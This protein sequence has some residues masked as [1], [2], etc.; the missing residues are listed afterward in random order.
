M[1][2]Y[3][4]GVLINQLSDSFEWRV[5]FLDGSVSDH[6]C[7]TVPS[8]KFNFPPTPGATVKAKFEHANSFLPSL[9]AQCGSFEWFRDVTVVNS[10]VVIFA[11]VHF[12]NECLERDPF[13][14]N[15]MDYSIIENENTDF[16]K[17]VL[18]TRVLQ[19]SITS[20][21][22]LQNTDTPFIYRIGVCWEPISF[23]NGVTVNWRY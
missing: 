8:E 14:I 7:I 15:G 13:K 1:H 21:S 19:T 2:F 16:Q 22:N 4:Y 3:K 18:P 17:I 6:C 5:A 12:S 23:E 11:I 9:V 20:R 10:K